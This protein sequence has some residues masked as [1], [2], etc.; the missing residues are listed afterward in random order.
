MEV[1]MN[2]TSGPLRHFYMNA[3]YPGKVFMASL[4]GWKQRRDRY[5]DV[6]RKALAFLQVSQYWPNDKLLE[7][8]IRQ[9]DEF[10]RRAVTISE[11]YRIRS[12]YTEIAE[13]GDFADLPL[14]PKAE[15]H[16]HEWQIRRTDL[17]ETAHRM[18]HTSGTT[19]TSLTFP[20][21]KEA[22]QREYAYRALHN[23]W[24]G[25]SL[26]GRDRIAFC[27]GHPVAFIDRQRPPF[28]TYDIANNMLM[29]SSYHLTAKNLPQYI[30]ELERFQP[31][32]ISG[33]PSSLYLL[34]LAYELYGTGKLRLRSAFTSSETLF[35][36]QREKIASAFGVQV[37]NY[38]GNTEMVSNGMECEHGTIHLKMEYSYVEVLNVENKP[39]GPGETGRLVCTGFG[40]DA[41]PLIR[42]EIGDVVTVAESQQC[43]CGRSG[44]LLK[45]VLGRVED[46]VVTPDGRL[47]GRL[48]HIFKEAGN[49]E[50]AQIVQHSVH[51]V[52]LRVVRGPHFTAHDEEVV[53]AAARNRLGQSIGIRIEYV[54]SFPRTKN[55]KFRFV[56]STID[57]KA[58]LAHLFK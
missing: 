10:L 52:T 25:V 16:L 36:F 44:L 34:A 53:L 47:I 46:Y 22:F 21:S 35:D 20:V 15:V 24:G 54:E 23:S 41:F 12:E 38:Y 3:P 18:V 26:H 42:Y 30:R 9:R 31:M 5:G 58:V 43:P 19:G 32:M 57:Q 6:F 8:Q 7:Y 48:D 11:Y 50:Q 14:L 40:N 33:Y 45:S 55:G 1:G 13:R 27:A 28:W 49:V 17:A 29:M 39:C 2:Y 51:E 4:Y 37:F 56:D